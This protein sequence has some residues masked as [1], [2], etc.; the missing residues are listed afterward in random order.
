MIEIRRTASGDPLQF[1]VT[2]RDATGETRHRVTM[3]QKTCASLTAGGKHSAEQCL[4]AT[5]RFLL[6]REPKEAILERFDVTVVSRYFPDFESRLPT[7]LA[8][9]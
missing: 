7:Y 9:G 4:E 2:V 8:D 5:F 6:D 3:S 1:E